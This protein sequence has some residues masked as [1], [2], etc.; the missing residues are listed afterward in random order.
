MAAG[1]D[2]RRGWGELDT[3]GLKTTDGGYDAAGR[4]IRQGGHPLRLGEQWRSMA[5]QRRMCEEVGEEVARP[6]VVG[7]RCCLGRTHNSG[8]TVLAR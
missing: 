4:R 8:R 6:S 5:A 2:V 3:W 7:H 1:L